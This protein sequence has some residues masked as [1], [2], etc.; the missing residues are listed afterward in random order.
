MVLIYVTLMTDVLSVLSFSLF[1]L[2]HMWVPVASQAALHFKLVV[3]HETYLVVVCRSSVGTW[4]DLSAAG[5]HS[6]FNSIA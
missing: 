2:Y 5:V 1:V 6:F 3:Y 4:L